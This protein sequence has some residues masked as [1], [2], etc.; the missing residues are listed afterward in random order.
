[1]IVSVWS[2][3][4]DFKACT[5]DPNKI[6]LVINQPGPSEKISSPLVVFDMNK[7]SLHP[8]SNL[9]KKDAPIVCPNM[10]VN[11]WKK[12][13]SKIKAECE[14]GTISF[15]LTI[16]NITLTV[17]GNYNIIDDSMIS[18]LYF[19]DA[20]RIF[21]MAFHKNWHKSLA[22]NFSDPNVW[23]DWNMDLPDPILNHISSF[24]R[25][26]TST[27]N[28]KEKFGII[29]NPTVIPNASLIAF[30]SGPFLWFTYDDD[31][32]YELAK[33]GRIDT[34]RQM[35]IDVEKTSVYIYSYAKNRTENDT[36][37][38]DLK[39]KL[40]YYTVPKGLEP[41]VIIF[42]T[43]L[44]IVSSLVIAEIYTQ[45]KRKK[46][47]PFLQPM[48]LNHKSSYKIST[49]KTQKYHSKETTKV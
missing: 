36:Y 12:P 25:T 5:N 30:P 21:F 6:I 29:E 17:P 4:L 38:F 49:K 1:M 40:N 35:I 39:L 7:V 16:D 20:E 10:D 15:I 23:W 24:G 13:L 28:I 34:R 37:S 33:Y 18:A 22:M 9:V 44:A 48:K 31:G 8:Y 46:M 11:I 41:S 42:F 47:N 14:N 3:N 19:R 2:L 26:F 45:R 43:S 27:C 32:I